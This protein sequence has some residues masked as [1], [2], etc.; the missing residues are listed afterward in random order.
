MAIGAD[1]VW[2]VRPGGNAANGAGFDSTISG[3]GV[4]YTQ[5]D[6]AQ[7]TLSDIACSASTTVTSA[8]GGF[9]S[10]MIGNAIRITGGGSTTGY[11]FITG[12]TNTNTITVDRSP[13][14][15]SGGSG[16]VGGASDRWQT[17]ANSANA[18]GNKAVA[19]NTIYIRGAG[20]DQPT[21]NDYASTGSFTTP[22]SGDST[23]GY[24]KFVGENGRPRIS[25]YGLQF[26]LGSRVLYRNLYLV[27][28]A[29]NFGALGVISMAQDCLV[30]DVIVDTNSQSTMTAIVA[31]SNCRIRA[32]TLFAGSTKPSASASD[33]H[34]I[35]INGSAT[36]VLISDC[37]IRHMGGSAINAASA[38]QPVVRNCLMYGCAKNTID[39]A[40]T[41]VVHGCTIDGGSGHGI[42]FQAVGNVDESHIVNCRITGHNQASKYAV[43]VATG[44][45]AQADRLKGC[46]NY[47]NL[48]GN[49][50]NYN[51]ISGGPND[52]TTTNPA[53]VDSA[54]GNY[55]AT[56]SDSEGGYGGFLGVTSY[57]EKGAVQRRATGGGGTNIFT[58]GIIGRVL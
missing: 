31:A 29:A 24:V 9:T 40:T 33:G 39:T 23:N 46:I 19:G 48:Y 49:T 32:S 52:D 2:R 53:Y 10:A 30:D 38:S 3:A 27:A 12:Q 4:D 36:S 25:E 20:S 28:S 21:S 34:G 18:T 56:S 50:G 1:T 45:T 22:P 16:R 43:N 58:S 14:T 26:Y 54:N 41:I 5:Q 57:I 47:N 15:V 13:G 11:Y 44:T 7:I 42:N 51:G 35:S 55:T 6:A 17:V 37:T 8:T